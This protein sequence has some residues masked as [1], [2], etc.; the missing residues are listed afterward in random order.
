MERL[1]GPQLPRD[2]KQPEKSIRLKMAAS[3]REDDVNNSD[4]GAKS[5]DDSARKQN[6]KIRGMKDKETISR[7]EKLAPN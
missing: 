6:Q 1:M 3:P 2:R 7:G 4:G 5:Q